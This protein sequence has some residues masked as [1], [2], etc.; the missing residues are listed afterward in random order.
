MGT[1]QHPDTYVNEVPST[2]QGISAIASA[3]GAFEGPCLQGPIDVAIPVTSFSEYTGIF[4][5]W[6]ANSYMTYVLDAFFRQNGGGLTY[7]TR[8][9][10]RNLTAVIPAGSAIAAM[11]SSGTPNSASVVNISLPGQ[12]GAIAIGTVLSIGGQVAVV[13]TASTTSPNSATVQLIT[14]LNPLPLG[15][16]TVGT[17]V[18]DFDPINFKQSTP[19]QLFIVD[20]GIGGLSPLPTRLVQSIYEGSFYNG[21]SVSSKANPVLTTTLAASVTSGAT[22]AT[23]AATQ[24]LKVGQS[25][26][27]G[28]LASTPAETARIVGILGNVVTFASPLT[29]SYAS[30][31]AVTET[32][33]DFIV[34]SYGA[35]KEYFKQLS[36]SPYAQTYDVGSI[37]NALSGSSYV[38]MQNLS[39]ANGVNSAPAFIS[40]QALQY[41]L[42]GLFNPITSASIMTDQ[43]YIGVQASHTGLYS[44]DAIDTVVLNVAVPG[45]TTI[46]VQSAL[47]AYATTRADAF[48]VLDSTLGSSPANVAALIASAASF[49]TSYGA[50]YYPWVRVYDPIGQGAQASKLIP[51]CGY[52]IGQYGRTDRTRGVYKAPA[53]QATVLLGSTGLEYNCTNDDHDLLNPIGVSVIKAFTGVGNVIF[54]ARTLSSASGD[55]NFN[56]INVRRMFLQVE[57]ELKLGTRFAV[58]EPITQT[59]FNTLYLFI[60]QYLQDKFNKGWF[61]GSTPDQCY[62]IIINSS[63]NTAQTA[64]LN[65]INISVAL[66]PSRPGEFIYINVSQMQ[67]GATVSESLTLGS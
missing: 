52:A 3:V 18:T 37:N 8:V 6:T 51:P 49:N 34:S 50:L 53:G 45:V 26:V 29:N 41:G 36:P 38:T 22:S 40:N 30:G 21:I 11:P 67:S 28:P 48:A 2:G 56:V 58:F 10:H 23:L 66:A 25:V 4:G 17:L 65:Q 63:N 54:G 31:V 7:I 32:S 59:T 15:L 64:S 27:I 13:K 14:L 5:S 57:K 44:F 62:Q 43:D 24:G 60:S 55:T 9:V 12:S 47:L 33:Y 42:D 46:A 35:Q 19:S 39:D 1:G 20:R 16:P 61:A